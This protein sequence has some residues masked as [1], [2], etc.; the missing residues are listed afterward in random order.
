VPLLPGKET[1]QSPGWNLIARHP[2][3]LPLRPAAR[4]QPLRAK[5]PVQQEGAVQ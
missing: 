5:R 2:V 1:L 3:P 4:D